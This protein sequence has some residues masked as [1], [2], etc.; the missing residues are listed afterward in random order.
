MKIEFIHL[1][2]VLI[3]PS[4]GYTV[5]STKGVASLLSDTLWR[6]LTFPITYLLIFILI[7]TAILQIH[8]VNRAL[9][10]FDSTQV[11]PT[12]FVLFTISVIIGSAILYRD[13]EAA[14]IERVAK[15]VGGCLL[16]F[17]GVYLITSG[18]SS[19]E[20]NEDEDIEDEEEAIGLIDEETPYNGR[21]EVD[22]SDEI[23]KRKSPANLASYDGMLHNGSRRASR[24][25][26][27]GQLTLTHTPRRFNSSNSSNLS[28][29]P[30]TP[31]A[32]PESPFFS[33]P[34]ASSQEHLSTRHSLQSTSSS[35]VLPSE[36]QGN[37]PSTDRAAS[38]QHL[39]P[40][41]AERPLTMTRNSIVRMLPGPLVSPLSSSLTAVVADNLRRGVDSPS[42]PRRRRGLSGVHQ[43]QTVGIEGPDS[44][45]LRYS[46]DVP[47]DQSEDSPVDASR[48]KGRTR[49][50]SLSLGSFFTLRRGNSKSE[51]P[52]SEEADRPDLSR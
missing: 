8:Y 42:R 4:G 47:R 49:S 12:Q 21:R 32:A 13:F 19:G 28:R 37:R 20:R 16:T 30:H 23:S 43:R 25:Q 50:M 51:G 46:H 5:L 36:S 9:Q 1:C 24:Q 39:L 44:P 15:F 11:I 38:Q 6:A 17:L 3:L 41:R 10:R 14:T 22:D 18:R 34:W 35:P 40:P 7:A 29:P 48:G 52:S 26:S 27:S 33:K 2:A 45:L 31:D